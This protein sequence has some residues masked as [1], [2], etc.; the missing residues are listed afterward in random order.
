MTMYAFL[1]CKVGQFMIHNPRFL[2]PDVTLRELERLFEELDFNAFPVVDSGKLVGFVT[3]FDFLK[4]FQ[5]TTMQLVPHY[6][7]LMA[8]KGYYYELYTAQT[9]AA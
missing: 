6:D 4:A 2:A 5:F 1:E 8:K 3:K 7:E 9:Q